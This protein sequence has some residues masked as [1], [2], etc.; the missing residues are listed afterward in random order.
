VLSG[1]VVV[2]RIDQ[3]VGGVEYWLANVE[4]RALQLTTGPGDML[5]G[6]HSSY[7][8]DGGAKPRLTKPILSSKMS[9]KKWAS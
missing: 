3:G 7:G 8:F 4:C 9:F 5:F 6:F 1:G 2:R